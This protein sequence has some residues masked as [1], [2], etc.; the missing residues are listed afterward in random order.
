MNKNDELALLK[1]RLKNLQDTP[2]N[3]KSGGVVRKLRR[4]IRNFEANM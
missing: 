3:I 2:K 1:N 4:Q